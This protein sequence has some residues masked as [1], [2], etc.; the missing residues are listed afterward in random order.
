MNKCEKSTASH[1]M[2]SVNLQAINRAQ[3]EHL[4]LSDGMSW[5]EDTDS[6]NALVDLSYL[7]ELEPYNREYFCN[8]DFH[9]AYG[10]IP[11]VFEKI[12]KDVYA[13]GKELS[14]AEK[15]VRILHEQSDALN[16][17]TGWTGLTY[18][19]QAM[20]VYHMYQIRDSNGFKKFST[21]E[22]LEAIQKE[23]THPYLINSAKEIYE[24][25]LLDKQDK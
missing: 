25:Y 2:G 11:P 21:T 8:T 12:R 17:I 13:D 4:R 16:K 6:L 15:E 23:L 7:K 9:N 19:A 10:R 3:D 5:L 18:I 14:V 22:P 24:E 20:Y 1:G